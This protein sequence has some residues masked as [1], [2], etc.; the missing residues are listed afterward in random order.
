MGVKRIPGLVALAAFVCLSANQSP[1]QDRDTS[2]V[3]MPNQTIYLETGGAGGQVSLNFDRKLNDWA[4]IRIGYGR[5][6]VVG[7]VRSSPAGDQPSDPNKHASFVPLTINIVPPIRSGSM[8]RVELAAGIVSGHRWESG[9]SHRQF[10]ALTAMVG[11][12]LLYRPVV[13]RFGMYYSVRQQG[14]FPR[15]GFRPAASVG[16]QF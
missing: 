7:K 15:A 8:H 6:F 5:W 1:A 9:G 3:R 14:D 2:A 16:L 12:R 13:L 10:R 4:T 11:Y